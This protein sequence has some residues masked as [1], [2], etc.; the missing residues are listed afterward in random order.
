MLEK[1]KGLGSDSDRVRFERFLWS[2]SNS[3]SARKKAAQELRWYLAAWRRAFPGVQHLILAHSHGGTVAVTAVH[4]PDKLAE[5]PAGRG[6]EPLP[7]VKAVD[8][9]EL[10][11]GMMTLGTPFV[12]LASRGP[13]ENPSKLQEAVSMSL[14]TIF[15]VGAP[16]L[17]V[18]LAVVVLLRGTAGSTTMWGW[19][20]PVLAF[21]AFLG[22]LA[23]VRRHVALAAFVLVMA[24]VV[25]G[26][27]IIELV[28]LSWI[29]IVFA[30]WLNPKLR[31]PD[32]RDLVEDEALCLPCPLVAVRTPGDE[33]SLVIGLGQGLERV[34]QLAAGA[35]GALGQRFKPL[36]DWLAGRPWWFSYVLVA[37]VPVLYPLIGAVLVVMFDWVLGNP[38][39]P[40]SEV[41]VRA[42]GSQGRAVNAVSITLFLLS[43]LPGLALSLFTGREALALPAIT[44][45]DA[46]PLPFAEPECRMTLV[47]DV[48]A[49][50]EKPKGLTHSLHEVSAIRS[51]IACW[52]HRAILHPMNTGIDLERQILALPAA[53]RE[54]LATVAW[55]SLVDDPGAAGDRNIDAEGIEIAAQRDAEIESGQV[56]PIGHPEFLRHTGG[57]S[58]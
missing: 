32:K 36:Y 46:E 56:Q 33:A 31:L 15:L 12:R 49:G 47:I 14:P 9:T 11:D 4:T 42:L 17:A 50:R 44:G 25:G 26:Y 1:L 30:Y 13:K 10:A 43:A 51:R 18:L 7:R 29:L 16:V 35:I 21:L 20:L 2:G 6:C 45:V 37:L 52:I 57:A 3:F 22:F 41:L 28:L 54:R 40:L 23:L 34:F 48:E 53:E 58:E 8:R 24:Y 27:V 5:Q 39:R 55:E 38:G 19:A